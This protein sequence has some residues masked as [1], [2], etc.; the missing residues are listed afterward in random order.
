MPASRALAC[1]AA[2]LTFAYVLRG[3]LAGVPITALEV[4]LVLLLVVYVVEKRRA[5]E[6]FPDPRQFAYFWPLALLLVAA[7]VALALAPD[8]RAAGGLWKAYFLEPALGAYVIADVFRTRASLG[9]L[10]HAFFLGGVVVAVLNEAGFLVAVAAHR[11]HLVE[12]PVVVLFNSPNATGL[13]LGPLMAAAAAL[14]LFGDGAERFRGAIFFAIATPAL[15]FSF[16]RGAWLGLAVA[17]LLLAALHRR[18]LYA[19]GAWLAAVL[20]VLAV[21]AVRRRIAH[22]FAP[23]DSLNSVNTRVSLW[24]AVFKMMSKG[25]HPITGHGLG[26]F[27]QAIAPYKSIGG[28]GEDLPYAHNGFLTFWTETGLLGLVAFCWLIVAAARHSVAAIRAHSPQFAYHVAFASAAVV[29]LVHGQF[30]VPYFKNDLSWMTL[31]L[32]GMHAAALRIDQQTT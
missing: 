3:R 16:S 24:Q 12:D 17:L 23:H 19:V 31:A 10:L 15:A 9:K 4:A 7:T 25:L 1:L 11:P 2:A 6:A 28:Y 13:Y 27:H 32:L 30:D 26:G 29:I 18:R 14:M 21:P 8:K 20:A 5:H 22:E